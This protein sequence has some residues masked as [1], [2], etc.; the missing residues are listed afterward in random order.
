M[1]KFS[2]FF[3]TIWDYITSPYYRIAA[4]R[5]EKKF[6]KLIEMDKKSITTEKD[7]EFLRSIGVD[8]ADTLKHCDKKA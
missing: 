7:V 2:K 4:I 3:K 5:L 1:N 6:Q 8:D